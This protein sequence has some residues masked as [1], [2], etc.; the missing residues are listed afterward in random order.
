[1]GI[2][3]VFEAIQEAIKTPGPDLRFER[4]LRQRLVGEYRRRVSIQKP[5][6]ENP[7]EIKRYNDLIEQGQ[8]DLLIDFGKSLV[9]GQGAEFVESYINPQPISE[10]Q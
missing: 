3:R 4:E 8:R 5:Q 10:E 9:S 6:T 7:E 1:M 2:E